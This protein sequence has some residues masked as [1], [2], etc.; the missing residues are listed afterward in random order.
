MGCVQFRDIRNCTGC[1]ETAQESN[2][3]IKA[4]VVE[5][6]TTLTEN[7][8]ETDLVQREKALYIDLLDEDVDA[9]FQTRKNDIPKVKTQDIR[10]KAQAIGDAFKIKDKLTPNIV[11]LDSG[12]LERSILRQ[13]EMKNLNE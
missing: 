2:G 4:V 10:K 6:A 8:T 11:M 7:I 5:Y 3:E 12:H 9:V 13:I 1:K